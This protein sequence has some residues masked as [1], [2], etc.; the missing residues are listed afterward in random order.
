MEREDYIASSRHAN[1][2]MLIMSPF[3]T[4]L[5]GTRRGVLLGSPRVRGVTIN[6]NANWC[7]EKK[8]LELFSL[9]SDL[10][11]KKK[12]EKKMKLSSKGIKSRKRIDGLFLIDMCSKNQH[13]EWTWGRD[14]VPFLPRR[15]RLA[16]VCFLGGLFFFPP[17]TSHL[18]RVIP[19][20]RR[21]SFAK[22]CPYT[23]MWQ[24]GACHI[25]W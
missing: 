10:K 4:Y 24:S 20:Q 19:R 17:V 16:H 12:E 22:D 7:W 21:R 6:W 8:C 3:G 11:K 9:F 1:F 25:R 2:D 14:F 18:F 13:D 23:G 5:W 15:S